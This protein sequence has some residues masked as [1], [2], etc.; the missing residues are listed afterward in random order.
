MSEAAKFS[1]RTRDVICA[2]IGGL[3]V[4]LIGIAF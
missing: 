1:V 3:I 2:A 4:Y